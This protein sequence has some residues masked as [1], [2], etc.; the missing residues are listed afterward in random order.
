MKAVLLLV[1]ALALPAHAEDDAAGD[2]DYFVMALTWSPT[3]ASAAQTYANGCVFAHS[4]AP[5][6]GENL[7]KGHA[8]WT[9]CMT[10]WAAEE[11]FYNYSSPGFSAQTGHFTQM[12]WA[13]TSTI[14]CG[15]APCGGSPL[16]VCQYAPPGNVIGQFSTNVLAP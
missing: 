11:R 4:G 7:C 14:G 13:S 6:V 5:D 15:S 9:A 16:Y 1:L 12:V 8:T 3:L 10:A 2:F